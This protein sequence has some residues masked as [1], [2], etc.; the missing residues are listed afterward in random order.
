M[1]HNANIFTLGSDVVLNTHNCSACKV[2]LCPSQLNFTVTIKH[3]NQVR[4]TVI[5]LGLG[6][7][8]K[9]ILTTS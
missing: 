2:V 5:K 6:L 8:A 1:F 7:I 4:I 9:I 3:K